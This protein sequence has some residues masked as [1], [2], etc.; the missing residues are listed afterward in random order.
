MEQPYDTL[1]ISGG[2]MNGLGVLGALQYLKDNNMLNELRNFVGTSAGS[3]IC[4]F[5]IIGYTPIE[6]MVYICTN[7]KLFDNLKT[8]DFIKA[9]KGDGAI[10][11]ALISDIIE[12][13]TIDK[14]GR[15]LLLKDLKETY[16]KTFVCTTFNLTKNCLEYITNESHPDMPCI[17][18]IHMSCNIPVIFEPYKYGDCLYVDGGISDNFPVDMGEKI[19]NRVVGLNINTAE[20]I[21]FG[22]INVMEY[23]YKLLIIVLNECVKYKIEHSKE[24]TDIIEIKSADKMVKMFD[25]DIDSKA[26]LSLFSIGYE[27]AKKYF[28]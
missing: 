6:V 14:V 1:V 15:P 2:S 13:M 9:T 4:Y 8:V 22:S 25:F 20:P 28:E 26:K 18:A 23:A 11:F 27:C 5:L 7:Q 3:I 19:G 16:G 24:T 21:V 10:S 12:K 17:S